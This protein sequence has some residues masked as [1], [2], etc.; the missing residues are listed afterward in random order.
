M[1]RKIPDE[2]IT[3]QADFLIPV[4]RLKKTDGFWDKVATAKDNINGNIR[5]SKKRTVK[6]AIPAIT[7]PYKRFIKKRFFACSSNFPHLFLQNLLKLNI[8]IKIVCKH[9]STPLPLNL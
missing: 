5:R 2:I 8:Y 1:P 7:N 3:A 6:I 4:F 9:T